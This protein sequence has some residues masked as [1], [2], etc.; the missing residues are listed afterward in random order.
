MYAPPLFSGGSGRGAVGPPWVDA[1]VL[2][3]AG[4]PTVS[5]VAPQ[6]VHKFPVGESAYNT[7]Q[8]CF[9]VGQFSTGPLL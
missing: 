6:G 4:L 3:A 7:E 1:S 2:L 5:A 9:G 8:I